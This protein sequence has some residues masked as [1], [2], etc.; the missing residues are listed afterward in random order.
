MFVLKRSRLG[1]TLVEIMIVLAILGAIFGLLAGRVTGARD[2]AA[3]RE[4]K[5]QMG[6][7]IQ[8]LQMYKLDCGKY[9]SS[10]EGLTKADP[11]CANWGPDPYY[12]SKI[13]D[14]W[15]N[16]Y[17]YSLEGSDFVLKSLGSDGKEGGSGY[18]KDID[19]ADS[20]Q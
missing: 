10:L 3:Q 16:P 6:Q 14:P 9:P 12:R 13:T 8:A 1:F 7:L 5:I 18:A 15:N 2:K 19:S 11:D 4:A 20:T 17:V